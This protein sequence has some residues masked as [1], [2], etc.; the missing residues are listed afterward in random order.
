[1]ADHLQYQG[2]ELEV[3]TS[4]GDW[5]AELLHLRERRDFRE[6]SLSALGQFLTVRNGLL[7]DLTLYEAQ[8]DQLENDE[9]KSSLRTAIQDT[10]LELERVDRHLELLTGESVQPDRIDLG[11]G[12]A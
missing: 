4:H 2:S 5:L 9:E 8:L 10:I 1:M 11:L 7:R 12:D 6:L 3:F